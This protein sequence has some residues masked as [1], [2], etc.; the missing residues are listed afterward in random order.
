MCCSEVDYALLALRY[1]LILMNMPDGMD[2]NAKKI[3]FS[4]ACESLG[5]LPN[6]YILARLLEYLQQQKTIILQMI[7]GI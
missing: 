3:A 1:L 7:K 2:N 4:K 5:V 6:D